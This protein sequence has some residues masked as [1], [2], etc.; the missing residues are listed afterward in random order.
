MVHSQIFHVYKT[1]TLTVVGL[2]GQHLLEPR[3][4][5][6]CRDELLE[7]IGSDDCQ[8]LVVDLVDVGILSSWV[9]GILASVHLQGIEVHIYHPASDM[10]GVLE[11]THFDELLNVR[12]GL[13]RVT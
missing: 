8:V 12:E 3:T 6:E 5:D 9:L 1:G 7:L 10:R 13:H 2:N 4:V 11:M